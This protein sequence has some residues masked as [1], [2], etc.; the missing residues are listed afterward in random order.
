MCA[1]LQI[2]LVDPGLCTF[3]ADVLRSSGSY[4]KIGGADVL[5]SI[6]HH[7]HA[8]QGMIEIV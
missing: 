2:R 4:G 5:S 7:F 3:R 8:E 1:R 6:L